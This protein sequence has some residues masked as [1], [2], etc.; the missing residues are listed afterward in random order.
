MMVLNPSNMDFV[1]KDVNVK[2]RINIYISTACNVE[3]LIV[4]HNPKYH[5]LIY[6]LVSMLQV[7]AWS[8]KALVRTVPKQCKQVALFFC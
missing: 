5:K 4:L 3:R 7:P 1:K 2:L 6:H 8:L